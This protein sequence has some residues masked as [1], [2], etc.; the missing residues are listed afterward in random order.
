ML[1]EAAAFVLM[2]DYSVLSAFIGE[3]DAARRAGITP[4]KNAEIAKA[5]AAMPRAMGSQ[6][7]TP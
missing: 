2:A 7:E 6:L 5:M 4:A 3:V 1:Y